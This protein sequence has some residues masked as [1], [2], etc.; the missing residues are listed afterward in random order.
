MVQYLQR[1]YPGV[2]VSISHGDIDMTINDGFDGLKLLSAVSGMTVD[3]ISNIANSAAG[4]EQDDYDDD[5]YGDDDYDDDYDG[6][7]DEGSEA[8]QDALTELADKVM[9]K[10]AKDLP[11]GWNIR[12]YLFS[13]ERDQYLPYFSITIGS[14]YSRK[15]RSKMHEWYHI[16]TTDNLQNVLQKGLVPS[17]SHNIPMMGTYKNRLFLMNKRSLRG[18]VEHVKKL[19][20]LLQSKPYSGTLGVEFDEPEELKNVAILK[21]IVP[22]DVVKRVDSTA[23]QVHGVYVEQPI[24]PE[25]I[26]VVYQGSIDKITNV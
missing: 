5:D 8:Y 18:G 7:D 16:T 6:Y 9:T 22:D 20:R 3:E 21:V 14:S 13:F 4:N 2:D 17:D 11:E 15:S 25:N 24:P 1:K 10:F 23:G 26:Q 19:A 12:T